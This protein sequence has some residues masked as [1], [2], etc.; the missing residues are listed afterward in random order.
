MSTLPPSEYTPPTTNFGMHVEEEPPAWPKVIGIFSI[1]WGALG[2]PCSI[3]MIAATVAGSA[4]AEWGAQMQA[5]AAKNNPNLPAAPTTPFPDA[6]KPHV[7]SMGASVIAIVG[8][9]VLIVAGIALMQ[10]KANGRKLHLAY[11][12]ISLLGSLLGLIGA[13]I[14][15]QSSSEWLANNAA[16]PWADFMKQQSMGGSQLM[17]AV[18]G[19]VIAAIYPLFCLVWFLFIKKNPA[20]MGTARETI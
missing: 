3:C 11:V 20:D 9:I 18:V 7:L 1:V 13:V 8:V 6:L 5:Q 14:T 12:A 10:R 2:V 16:D 17:Q 15:A 4:L 19:T